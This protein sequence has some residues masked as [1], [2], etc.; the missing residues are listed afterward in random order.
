VNFSAVDVDRLS[1][2]IN[3]FLIIAEKQNDCE[4]D[5]EVCMYLVADQLARLPWWKVRDSG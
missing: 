5:I 3:I 1:F 2:E 4:A